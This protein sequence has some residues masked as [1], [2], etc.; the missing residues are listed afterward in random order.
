MED[1][2]SARHDSIG[3]AVEAAKSG[4]ARLPVGLLQ[5]GGEELLADEGVTV[6]CIIAADGG[7]PEEPGR[8]RRGR[9]RRTR[10]LT[11]GSRLAHGR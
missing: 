10:L 9:R 2:D 1:R 3:D 11:V 6:R 8:S 5:D 4:F 7:L